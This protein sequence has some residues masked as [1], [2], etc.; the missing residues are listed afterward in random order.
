[1]AT[2]KFL[3]CV[4]LAAMPA[5]SQVANSGSATSD[6]ANSTQMLIPPPISAVGFPVRTGGEEISNYLSGGVTFNG[7]Y[8]NNLYPGTGTTSINEALYLVQPSLSADHTTDRSHETFTYAP[9][10]T[11]YDP[12]STLNGVNQT[13]RAAFQYRFSPHTT[14]VAG[15]GVTKTSNALSEPLASGSVSGELPPV[16][17]GLIVPYAPQL[18]N[19]AYAQLGWQF[20]LNDMLGFDGNATLLHFY[21]SPEARGL[22]NSNSSGG[23]AF[24]THRLSERQYFG[25]SYEYSEVA[26][27]PNISN[28]IA[29]A[30]LNAHNLLAF[31]T[32]YPKS[33]FSLSF[34]GGSQHYRLT[35]SPSAPATG[36][37]PSALGSIGWQG[38]H[39][40]FALTYSH[41]VTEGSGVI[42]AYNTN[43]A[44][45][46]GRW[47]LSRNWSASLGGNYAELAAVDRSFAGSMP[48]GH[49][50]SGTA[51]L[52]R[53]LGANLSFTVQYERIHEDY[54]GIPA[55]SNAPN[56]SL[57]SGS[58]T[59]RFSRPLGQ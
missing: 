50:L 15:D 58:I 42:G 37:A 30:D 8:V 6:N 10:F 7:G 41:T 13:G 45:L 9:S 52:G 32:I 44:V 24:Y 22:Y 47:Q 28:G 48:G 49:S 21:N 55:I 35:Q 23:A 56:S 25:A 26:A 12:D 43:A 31:Y 3:F 57:E 36:W 20:S 34:G 1:M 38:I 19:S 39:T 46:S 16:T 51:S 18:S 29:E 4:L 5:C 40:S 53:Q 11:F 59:Y 14:F 27:K 54:A 17:P 2:R 33:N